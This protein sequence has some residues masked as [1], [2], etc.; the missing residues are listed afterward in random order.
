MYNMGRMVAPMLR[1][2]P[3]QDFGPGGAMMNGLQQ[4]QKMR[5]AQSAA[6]PAPMGGGSIVSGGPMMPP[7]MGGP[8]QLGQGPMMSA[9]GTPQQGA[10]SR[11]Q[12]GAKSRAQPNMMPGQPQ[13]M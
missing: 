5:M 8:T 2:Q 10:K 3:Q 4:M 11:P 1:K 6:G 9:S 12:P 13:S 7:Q